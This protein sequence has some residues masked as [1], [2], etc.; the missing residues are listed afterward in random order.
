MKK[1]FSR[2]AFAGNL[3][4]FAVLA[5]AVFFIGCEMDVSESPVLDEIEAAYRGLQ[6]GGET[7]GG[8]TGSGGQTGGYPQHKPGPSFPYDGITYHVTEDGTGLEVSGGQP[9]ENGILRIPPEVY[10][11][12]V[13]GIQTQ[14]FQHS[15]HS[16]D[17]R[18]VDLSGCGNLQEI[19]VNAFHACGSLEAVDLSGCPDLKEIADFAFDSCP[20]LERLYLCGS[21]GSL[22]S[23]SSTAFSQDVTIYVE[24]EA[25]KTCL[26]GVLFVP[27]I[28]EICPEKHPHSS[29]PSP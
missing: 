1:V 23:V 15:E 27:D 12:P 29:F 10:G 28:V 18:F 19:R 8:N 9:D 14:A 3:C 22:I 7:P 21:A 26:L 20:S 13:T 25:E 2:P 5:A 16:E 24:D 17:I 4:L 11:L 6:T